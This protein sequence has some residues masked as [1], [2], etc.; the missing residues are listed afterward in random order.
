[1]D[2]QVVAR[3]RPLVGLARHVLD[4][5]SVSIALVDGDELAYVVAEG[6]GADRVVGLRLH[7][8][9]GIGAYAAVS[10]QTVE[11]ASVVDDPRFARDVAESIGYVPDAI[12]AAPVLDEDGDVVGVLSVLDR[13]PDDRRAG[14]AI[15]EQ[16][17]AVA[18]TL[19]S[20]VVAP[21]AQR[22]IASRVDE[23]LAAVPTEDGDGRLA[24]DLAASLEAWL[25]GPS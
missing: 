15:A 25:A 14:L 2:D 3:L 24:R 20:P 19:L 9:R 17:A 13:G 12:L 5:T 23:R 10:G 6:R 7:L 11:V 8:G 18:G 1:M 21:D 4:A 16:L 22:S